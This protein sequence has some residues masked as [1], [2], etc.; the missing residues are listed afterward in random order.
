[1]LQKRSG[2]LARGAGLL[3]A[4]T[5]GAV[6]ALVGAWLFGGFHQGTSTVREVVAAPPEAAPANVA[7][8]GGALTIGEI[9]KTDAPGVVQITAKIL[10]QPQDPFF[11]TPFGFPQI[12]KALGSGFVLDKLGHVVTNYHVIQGARS[13][14]V[15]F[16][17]N[18]SMKARVVGADPSTD[19]AVLKVTAKSR[20]LTPLA[21]GNSDSVN[22]G[23]AV[24]ALGNP[25]GLSRTVTAGIVS[26]LQRQIQS[27]NSQPIDHVIQ[28]DAAI[29]PGNSG[30]P[31]LDTKGRVIGVNAQI[32]TGNTGETG[33]VGIGFAIPINTVKDVAA[34]L[35]RSGRVEH[36]FLGV[37][38]RGFSASFARLFRLPANHGLLVQRVYANSPAAM[39][40]L[41]AG[42][43][44]VVVAGESY[45]VGG[46]LIVGVDGIPAYSI[47]RLRD[48]L[49]SRKPGDTISL[50]IYRGTTHQTVNV[51]LGRQ[52]ATTPPSPG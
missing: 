5:A 47:A 17:N 39:A 22:V 3:S 16:S 43:S 37:D 40:G 45:V 20:A 30:G 26:A 32:S 25:F 52:P 6:V 10:T 51:K 35:I 49:S 7:A 18:D 13:I 15:S 27:P 19:I 9:Y 21:L 12:E 44:D 23:D 11:G 41:K 14:S 48:I 28:T 24:V 50:E 33:N 2:L 36:P 4:G 1:M 31:L 38:V 8:T 34:Q 46:D 29:N 42:T